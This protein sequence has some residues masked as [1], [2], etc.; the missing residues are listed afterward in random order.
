MCLFVC[1]IILK[2]L[3]KSSIKS[4]ENFQLD[5]R[6]LQTV[7]YNEWWLL[8]HR[9]ARLIGFILDRKNKIITI[10]QYLFSS[11]GRTVTSSN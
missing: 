6:I 3:S 8:H 4:V 1:P 5:P 2:E 7:D 9:L 10:P 11:V